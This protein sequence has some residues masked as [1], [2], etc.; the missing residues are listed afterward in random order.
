MKLST[1]LREAGVVERPFL[2]C[3]EIKV[4]LY[5]EDDNLITEDDVVFSEKLFA[6][7]ER[8][9]ND[10]FEWVDNLDPDYYSINIQ[11]T[12]LHVV[13]HYNTPEATVLRRFPDIQMD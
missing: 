3:S 9:Y 2:E 6:N 12:P 1:I 8:S 5:D 13:L 4:N 7:N 11:V 10:F